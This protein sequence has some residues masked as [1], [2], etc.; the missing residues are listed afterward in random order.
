MRIEWMRKEEEKNTK[1]ISFTRA[2]QAVKNE[3]FIIFFL[4]S[5]ILTNYRFH[6]TFPDKVGFLHSARLITPRRYELES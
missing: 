1:D 3:I 5:F 2:F 6:S 4:F